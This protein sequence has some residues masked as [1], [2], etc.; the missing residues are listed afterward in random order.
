MHPPTLTAGGLVIWAFKLQHRLF[1]D[2]PDGE[3]RC[4]GNLTPAA[5]EHQ[6]WASVVVALDCALIATY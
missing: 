6:R 3:M 2:Q 4:I 5:P 1:G